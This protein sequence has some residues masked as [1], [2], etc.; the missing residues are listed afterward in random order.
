MSRSLF[1]ITIP[2]PCHEDWSRMHPDAKGKFCKACCH[3]VYDFSEKTPAEIREILLQQPSGK[4]CGY[5][6]ETQL[7]RPL[8]VM[9]D[10]RLMNF[11]RRFALALYVVFGSLLFSCKTIP[12]PEQKSQVEWMDGPVFQ[13]GRFIT[14]D[15]GRDSTRRMY[16]KADY[17][18]YLPEELTDSTMQR[19]E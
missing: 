17:M 9:L 6:K 16:G 12:E 19:S 15:S 13:K 1:Q 3:S 8:S 11:T 10:K 7:N 18:Q 14:H 4:I 2:E 5:F